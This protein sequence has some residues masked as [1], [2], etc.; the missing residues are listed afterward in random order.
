MAKNSYGFINKRY[1][2]PI[3]YDLI[4][5]SWNAI[6]RGRNGK[7]YMIEARTSF[8]KL[9]HNNNEIEYYNVLMQDE[10]CRRQLNPRPLKTQKAA[11]ELISKFCDL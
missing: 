10:D 3:K 1:P 7:K 5:A 11:I 8:F 4:F 2:Q 6:Y 9:Q